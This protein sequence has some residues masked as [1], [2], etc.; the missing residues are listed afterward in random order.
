MGAY[1]K[2]RQAIFAEKFAGQQRWRGTL[3][4]AHA[5]EAV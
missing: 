5:S 1:P 2:F 3:A 4:T